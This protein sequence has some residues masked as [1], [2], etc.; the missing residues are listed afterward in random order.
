MS[1]IKK[2]AG[3][4]LYYGL[5]S[6]AARFI[7]YLLTPYLTAVLTKQDFGRMGAVYS[8]IP[9]FNIIFTY[10][11]ETAYF[12]FVQKKERVQ[13]IN[14]TITI[15]LLCSTILLFALTWF[16][17]SSLAN[18]AS[19]KEFPQLI[20][21]SII[22]IALDALSTIPFA[23]LRNEG[24]PLLFAFIKI[25]GICI[26]VAVTIFFVSYCGKYVAVHPQSF[27]IFIYNP[28]DNPVKYILLA[29]VLQSAFTL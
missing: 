29:N 15:S 19:L 27:L 9:L 18:I 26:N 2:L 3:Q 21:L 22:I 5:S 23:R 14:S 16:N 11:M 4:T 8:M 7:N 6:I 24:R 28:T 25:A 17:Q 20:Q 13:S 10:G 12:R 1:N